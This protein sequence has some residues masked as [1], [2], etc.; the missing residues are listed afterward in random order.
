MSGSKLAVD[1]CCA[2][3]MRPHSA[4]E[5]HCRANTAWP[6]H[7]D[8]WKLLS[9]VILRFRSKCELILVDRACREASLASLATLCAPRSAFGERLPRGSFGSHAY[10]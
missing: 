4:F 10:S 8:R 1:G 3:L 2:S 9:S 6:Q 5:L 7:E